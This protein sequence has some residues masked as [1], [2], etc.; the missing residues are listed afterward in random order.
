[1][2]KQVFQHLQ[3][4]AEKQGLEFLITQPSNLFQIDTSYLH[5]NKTITL[6][7]HVP[8]VAED[9]KLNLLQFIPFP[10]SQSHGANTTVTPKV[11]KDLIAVGKHCQIKILGQTNLAA[12]TKLG[13][14]FLCKGR[15]VLRTNIKESCL[16]SLY[17]QHLPG[18][19]KNLEQQKNTCF[20]LMPCETAKFSIKPSRYETGPDPKMPKYRHRK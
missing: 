20:K 8:M 6:I 9:N 14:N 13:Q 16:G 15:S 2:L 4:Q 12:Y 5:S 19:L 1:M 3:D 11:D 18:T 7:L 17:M 10:L